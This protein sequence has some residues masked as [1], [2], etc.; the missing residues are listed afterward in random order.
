[1]ILNK[2]PR[3]ESSEQERNE[4]DGDQNAGQHIA[5]RDATANEPAKGIS[6][7]PH[8]MFWTMAVDR[9]H[10]AGRASNVMGKYRRTSQDIIG[11][12]EKRCDGQSQFNQVKNVVICSGACGD[13]G[14]GKKDQGGVGLPSERP[15][16]E[17]LYAHR[18]SS[19]SDY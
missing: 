9:K 5:R 11:P 6:P 4:G 8:T 1:M 17:L 13:K 16:R 3:E 19:T 2:I 14:R 7:S 18:N 12:Q 15:S 10:G